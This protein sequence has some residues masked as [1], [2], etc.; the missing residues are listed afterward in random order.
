MKKFTQKIYNKLGLPFFRLPTTKKDKKNNER[1]HIIDL[2]NISS[3]HMLFDA[4]IFPEKPLLI[5]GNYSKAIPI[6]Y[7][8]IKMSEKPC[9]V[10]GSSLDLEI[11]QTSL[12]D[13]DWEVIDLQDVTYLPEDENCLICVKNIADFL[14]LKQ[15]IAEWN[16]HLV[17]FCLGHGLQMDDE[18]LSLSNSI[19]HYILISDSLYRSVKDS[20]N[21]KLSVDQLLASMEYLLISSIGTAAKDLIKVLPEYESEK[22][23]NTVDFSL[24][25]DAG[26]DDKNPD[27]HRN[28]G[29]VHLGQ[30][31]TQEIKSVVTQDELTRLQDENKMLI[32][33][34]EK[35][36][37]FIVKV[38]S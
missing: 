20:A 17:L 32:Y 1:R 9:A 13:I 30:S 2:G 26:D 5:S 7:Q 21:V 14:Y 16:S 37:L 4:N 29:G 19:Q 8:L 28:G 38:S 11:F 3:A 10:I 25:K 27:H 15:N 6:V 34:A 24:H 33:N 23:T 12:T 18:L 31:I 36:Q 35:A 22:Q